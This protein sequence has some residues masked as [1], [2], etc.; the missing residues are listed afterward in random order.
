MD[1]NAYSRFFRLS[2]TIRRQPEVSLTDA[3]PNREATMN[4]R[5]KW[6]VDFDA[7]AASR[8]VDG[9]V[10]VNGYK[11]DSR[12]PEEVAM[13]E[14]AASYGAQAVFFE[15]GRKAGPPVAQALV[16]VS[17][18][19]ADDPQ[20][21]ELHQAPLAWGGVPLALPQDAGSR[22]ALPMRPQ[23]GFR[24]GDRRTSCASRSRR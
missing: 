11:P 19:P 18:G 13:M 24:V 9:L 17:D 6:L 20:F 5:A 21:A 8:V 15:A 1:S 23:A 7:S 10:P 12:P 3:F 4:D 16:F 14:K 22:A 2:G